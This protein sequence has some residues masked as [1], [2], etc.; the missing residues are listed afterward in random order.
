M[1]PENLKEII[2]AIAPSEYNSIVID[3]KT[4]V[5][6]YNY[7]LVHAFAQHVRYNT[8]SI[9]AAVDDELALRIMEIANPSDES[10]DS[11]YYRFD[12]ITTVKQ[13]EDAPRVNTEGILSSAKLKVA[14]LK[15]GGR[16]VDHHE[17]TLL[18]D[19][20]KISAIQPPFAIR[21]ECLV[22]ED[23]ET[24]SLIGTLTWLH[25]TVSE[26]EVNFLCCSDREGCEYVSDSDIERH[27]EQYYANDCNLVRMLT[28]Y[29]GIDEEDYPEQLLPILD[30]LHDKIGEENAMEEIA[31]C[32]IPCLSF[33]YKRMLTGE[34]KTGILIDFSGHPKLI[35]SSNGTNK[36]LTG[37]SDRV[38]SISHFFGSIGKTEKYKDK[39]DLVRSIR[40][41]I[42]IA[43]AD[44]TVTDEEK[45]CLIHSIR[46][47]E[48]LTSVEQEQLLTLLE[49]KEKSFLTD[50][51]FQFHSQDNAHETLAQMQEIAT[52]D[53]TVHENEQAIIDRMRQ[54][55]ES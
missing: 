25:P 43:V 32:Q 45:Q 2:Q 54:H 52:S 19:N 35:L 9:T 10:A 7:Y 8:R 12:D 49:S 22:K 31:Y 5:K 16:E 55:I 27:Y 33:T 11:R 24:Q 37:I 46:G 39:K 4:V 50:N 6:Q 21:S 48:R 3:N 51:D 14:E 29:N 41:L 17:I 47:M 23:E 20:G 34:T 53:G 44:N 26:K 1:T 28:H 30:I 36:F 18:T 38:K 13:M 15:N 40:L 42:A